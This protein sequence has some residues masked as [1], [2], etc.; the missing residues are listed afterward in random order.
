MMR[1]TCLR[2]RFAAAYSLPRC[3]PVPLTFWL[4]DLHMCSCSVFIV[5]EGGRPNGIAFVEFSTPQEANAAMV[6]NR[7]MMGNRYM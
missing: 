3:F 5:Q 7:Q 2:S 6:K 4:P 1:G